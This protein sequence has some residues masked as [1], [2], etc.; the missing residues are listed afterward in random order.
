MIIYYYHLTI[1][2]SNDSILEKLHDTKYIISFQSV[3]Q[4]LPLPPQDHEGRQETLGES[5]R[6][7]KEVQQEGCDDL[8]GFGYG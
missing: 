1:S 4:I 7:M 2:Y 5:P 3:L 8:S 6:N